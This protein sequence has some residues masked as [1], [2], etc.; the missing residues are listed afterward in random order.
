MIGNIKA[1][2]RYADEEKDHGDGACSYA[3]PVWCSARLCDKTGSPGGKREGF[4]DAGGKE[5]AGGLSE[6]IGGSEK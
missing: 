2:C 3:C 1:V 4:R 6:K 5:K